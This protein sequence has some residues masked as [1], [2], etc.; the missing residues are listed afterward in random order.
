MDLRKKSPPDSYSYLKILY[1]STVTKEHVKCSSVD[2]NTLNTLN[3][4]IMNASIF[5]GGT[6]GQ[7]MKIRMLHSLKEIDDLFLIY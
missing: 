5:P 1:I 2:M 6:E 7:S 3:F 4:N